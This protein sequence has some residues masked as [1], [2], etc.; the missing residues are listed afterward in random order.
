MGGHHSLNHATTWQMVRGHVGQFCCS[1]ALRADSPASLTTGSSLVCCPVG[2]AEPASLVR[3][4]QSGLALSLATGGNGWAGKASFSHLYY[5]LAD[6]GRGGDQL[7]CSHPQRPLTCVLDHRVSS[8]V[9][10]GWGAYLWWA[11]GPS[12]PSAGERSSPLRSKDS[13]PTAVSIKGQG[14]PSQ[15]S[16]G[17]G[18]SAQ[19]GSNDLV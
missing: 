17:Q 13:L 7:S 10:S 19:H 9:L 12:F 18:G 11:M 4:S 1:H 16:E 6:C 15:D 14:Q 8:G 5:H 3:C 2:E